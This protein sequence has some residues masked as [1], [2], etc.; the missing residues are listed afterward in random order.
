M[1]LEANGK[2]SA[3]TE[4]FKIGIVREIGGSSLDG[5]WNNS[6]PT[7]TLQFNYGDDEWKAEVIVCSTSRLNPY[8]I[9]RH[10]PF[11]AL[12]LVR[13]PASMSRE[14]QDVWYLGR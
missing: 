3:F 11:L 4:P 14:T 2:E 10:L 1:F 6:K 5:T 7:C 9:L 8:R 13:D 12:L